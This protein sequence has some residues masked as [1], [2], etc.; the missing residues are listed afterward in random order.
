M[1]PA[2]ASSTIVVLSVESIQSPQQH[3]PKVDDT[4]GVLILLDNQRSPSHTY[5]TT[6]RKSMISPNVGQLFEHIFKNP[7]P[8]QISKNWWVSS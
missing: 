1:F 6:K 8:E 4:T 7:E 3:Q 2:F 5:K